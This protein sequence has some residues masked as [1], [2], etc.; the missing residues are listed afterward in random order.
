[1][2]SINSTFSSLSNNRDL[3]FKWR[4][5]LA[6]LLGTILLVFVSCLTAVLT[7]LYEAPG[8]AFVVHNVLANV[9]IVVVI[10]HVIGPI[11]G[12]HCNPA[13]TLAVCLTRHMGILQGVLYLVAQIIGCVIGAALVLLIGGKT[14]AN[15]G[16]C[17]LQEPSLFL[18]GFVLEIILTF[19]L[20]LTIFGSA[21]KPQH[22]QN[23][24]GRTDGL[25]VLVPV[26]T[27]WAVAAAVGGC[28][29]T[30]V[31]LSGA[32]MNPVR[33][34]G[35]ELLSWS[36]KSYSWIYYTAPLIGGSLA[37]LVFEFILSEPK[38]TYYEV[39]Q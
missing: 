25:E 37:G 27:P 20:V 26:F 8:A 2:S 10:F 9:G 23:K 19:I 21:I 18:R 4:A 13:V 36:W 33:Q 5:V 29:F 31:L 30:G 14:S 15:L 6:E 3:H 28:A 7:N 11:S 39:L 12:A 24:D 35:P 16:A 38:K 17:S 1:M 32:C 34:L 22:L